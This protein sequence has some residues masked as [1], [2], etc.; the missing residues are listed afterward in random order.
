MR[1]SCFFAHILLDKESNKHYAVP[2]EDL[3]K[4]RTS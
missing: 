3:F 1:H 4:R 2:V